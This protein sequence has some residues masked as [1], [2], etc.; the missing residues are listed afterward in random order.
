MVVGVVSL[1]SGG[2][3]SKALLGQLSQG[4]SLLREG[5]GFEESILCGN[6]DTATVLDHAWSSQLLRRME[7]LGVGGHLGV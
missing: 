2:L 5:D 3:H 7:T 1:S 4:R 6:P